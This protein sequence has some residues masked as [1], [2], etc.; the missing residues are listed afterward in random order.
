VYREGD[1]L[2]VEFATDDN[3]RAVL[4]FWARIARRRCRST[5]AAHV[6]NHRDRGRRDETRARKVARR[7]PLMLVATMVLVFAS[8]ALIT[9]INVPSSRPPEV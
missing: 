6:A 9:R 1:A 4:P 5:V 8:G 2:R 7:T 3:P